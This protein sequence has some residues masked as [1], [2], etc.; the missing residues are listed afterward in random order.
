MGELVTTTEAAEHAYR[1][2]ATVRGWAHR[3]KLNAAGTDA[4][5]RPLYDLDDVLD[6]E[7]DLRRNPRGG[8]ARDAIARRQAS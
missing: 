6:V 8:R 1:D 5:G 4:E 7:R 3:G 2:P